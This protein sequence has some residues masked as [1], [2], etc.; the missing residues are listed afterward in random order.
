MEL[1]RSWRNLFQSSEIYTDLLTIMS[2]RPWLRRRYFKPKLDSTVSFSSGACNL[3]PLIS[4]LLEATSSTG[5]PL[6]RYYDVVECLERAFKFG[7]A[8]YVEDSTSPF[9]VRMVTST[10]H[11]VSITTIVHL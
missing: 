3:R 6:L 11:V 5:C 2:L 8:T 4:G 9:T 10:T 1:N 7:R